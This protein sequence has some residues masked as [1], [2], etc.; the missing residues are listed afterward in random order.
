MP[1]NHTVFSVSVV[2]AA[3]AIGQ[4]PNLCQSR[5]VETVIANEQ[6]SETAK[7]MPSPAL[8]AARA[9]LGRGLHGVIIRLLLLGLQGDV[10][11][12]EQPLGEPCLDVVG[13]GRNLLNRSVAAESF[14]LFAV[15]VQVH[16]TAT[17]P[18][19]ASCVGQARY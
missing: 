19:Q 14:D 8:T 12:C 1:P 7:D 3:T 4:V 10:V 17:R 18:L 11:S 9:F 2:C 6:F 13:I 5:A 15:S 16:R